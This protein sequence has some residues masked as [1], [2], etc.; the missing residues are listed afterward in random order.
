M[1]I[2][3]LPEA[4]GAANTILGAAESEKLP[5]FT[6]TCACAE[7]VM[8]PEVPVMVKDVVPG[9]AVLV[10]ESV[11]VLKPVVGFGEK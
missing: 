7:L 1:L 3:D 10:A 5:A 8:L 6:T 4:P 9:V 2:V 11:I